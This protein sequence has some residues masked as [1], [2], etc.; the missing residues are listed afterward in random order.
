[1]LGE[2]PKLRAMKRLIFERFSATGAGKFTDD[3]YDCR[4]CKILHLSWRV[5]VL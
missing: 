5:M 1:M 3:N 4:G 2:I